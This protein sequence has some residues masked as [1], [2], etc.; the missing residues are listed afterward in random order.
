MSA[1]LRWS[2]H[3]QFYQGKRFRI[4]I[5]NKYPLIRLRYIAGIKGLFK[6]EY[7]YHTLNLN[8][9]KRAYLSQLG[10]ADIVLEGGYTFGKLPYPLMTVHRAN[11]T[12]SYQL[13]SY[14]LMNFLEFVSDHYA[15]L[16]IDHKF[17]G[18]FFNKIPLLK[19]LQWREVISGKILWG[20]VR[21]ENNPAYNQS[22]LKFPVDDVN[23]L[24]TTYALGKT[25]YIE[26]S[27][28]ITNVFKLLRI[29]FVKRL[30]YLNNPNVT[31]WGI[32][33]RLRFDF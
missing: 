33:S 14:N 32:R 28:G 19:K 29:D 21:N 20:G 8:I 12:F 5:V 18:F 9:D 31:E 13:N 25:P 22:T 2:P 17:N 23:Q 30:T 16:S 26:V 15:A 7:N 1:E 24:P 3:Q 10:F 11:Q 27:A 6:G 4:P